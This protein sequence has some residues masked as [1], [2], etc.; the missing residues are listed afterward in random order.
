[1]LL[2]V[3]SD[4]Q[5]GKTYRQLAGTTSEG[6][7][8]GT[9]VAI[10]S[11]LVPT[12]FLPCNGVQYDTTTYAA[13]YA[14]LGVNTTPDLRECVLVGTGTS[15][16]Q[17]I[18]AHDVYT[19]GQFKDDQL[20]GFA[21]DGVVSVSDSDTL[22]AGYVADIT[23]GD[24]NT[25]RVGTTTHGKQIGVNYII[26]AT[27]GVTQV[28]DPEIYAQ[29]VG[30]VD[31][32]FLVKGD[33]L[34]NNDI[35]AY[36]EANDCCVNIPRP[37]ADKQVLTAN[38]VT[39]VYQWDSNYYNADFTAATE[40]TQIDLSTILGKM[41]VS[42]AHYYTFTNETTF[43]ATLLGTAIWNDVDVAHSFV[44][45]TEIVGEGV[46]YNDEWYVKDN[47]EWY[48]ITDITDGNITEG[49]IITDSATI[50]ALEAETL[51]DIVHNNYL[52]RDFYEIDA[53][54]ATGFVKHLVIDDSLYA[55]SI[56][57]YKDVTALS[58]YA[59]SYSWEGTLDA[60]SYVNS[61]PTSNIED[62]IYA[63]PNGNKFRYYAGNKDLQATY[64]IGT[65]KKGGVFRFANK[66]AAEAQ[67]AISDPEDDNYIP[68][69]SLVV[70]DDENQSILGELIDE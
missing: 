17:A 9:I 54:S 69:D 56:G 28:T 42:L 2:Q 58:T 29:L 19:I 44:T 55:I 20:Q 53:L 66:A 51:T 39:T 13:L 36:D 6:L 63:I 64:E 37:T 43:D 67:M 60:I 12:G 4:G 61:L 18:T 46:I 59:I 8:V 68:A 24:N 25:L 3:I 16:R 22:P 10:Y 45:A 50:A 30:Y 41:A 31:N 47:L 15:T 33:N 35:L 49:E 7:P 26:K 57:D 21:K 70:I 40:P 11:N 32:K 23:E 27:T 62:I 1:M 5:G 65:A 52:H 48:P 14:L 34:I 38:G